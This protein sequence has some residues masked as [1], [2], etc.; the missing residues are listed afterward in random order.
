[1][2]LFSA[3]FPKPTICSKPWCPTSSAKS[4]LAPPSDQLATLQELGDYLT[5]L[6]PDPCDPHPPPDFVD[7]LARR[8]LRH[9]PDHAILIKVDVYDAAF[10]T[11]RAAACPSSTSECRFPSTGRQGEF[12][13]KFKRALMAAGWKSRANCG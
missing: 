12:C 9:S 13:L 10:N 8:A 1:V 6:K 11:L 4:L 7:D 2:L 5:D 3:A